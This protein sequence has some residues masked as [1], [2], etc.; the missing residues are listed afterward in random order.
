MRDAPAPTSNRSIFDW[1]SS[2]KLRH[3]DGMRQVALTG[4]ADALAAENAL[5]R[6]GTAHRSTI[7]W[8]AVTARRRR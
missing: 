1:K 6:T 4:S 2:S 5:A 7:V 3:S 8:P